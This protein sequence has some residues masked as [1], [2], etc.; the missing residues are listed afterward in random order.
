MC[1]FAKFWGVCAVDTILQKKTTSM[2]FLL[3][4]IFLCCLAFACPRVAAWL[5][6]WLTGWLGKEKEIQ[7][8]RFNPKASGGPARPARS[9]GR[10]TNPTQKHHSHWD[11]LKLSYS[12]LFE[13]V[14]FNFDWINPLN[15][16]PLLKQHSYWHA[17]L[18]WYSYLSQSQKGRQICLWRN[19]EIC[20]K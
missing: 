20:S 10:P 1:P 17:G 5:T 8:S 7:I 13:R 16:I 18:I 14:G 12:R 15:N 3:G 9:A 2:H 19:P 4:P 11:T 6:D